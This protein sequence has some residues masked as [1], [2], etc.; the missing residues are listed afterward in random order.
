[1][2]NNLDQ[3]TIGINLDLSNPNNMYWNNAILKIIFP[4]IEDHDSESEVFSKLSGIIKS[5]YYG[6]GGSF[7][8]GFLIYDK[9]GKQ[10][11]EV[12]AS[13]G[14][15]WEDFEYNLNNEVNL[16]KF[17]ETINNEYTIEVRAISSLGSQASIAF[18]TQPE[19][20]FKYEN[21]FNV[22]FDSKDFYAN[23]NGR[24]SDNPLSP[25]IID[26]ILA[27]ELGQ[28]NIDFTGTDIMQ[29][30]DWQYAF[31]VDKKI[32]SKKLIE[33]IASAS[34]YIPRFDN[35]GNFKFDVIPIGGGTADDTIKEVDVIDF[36]FSRSKIEDVYT[37]IVFKYN[38]DY[39]RGEFNDSVTA[40][41]SL[42]GYEDEETELYKHDYYG[43]TEPYIEDGEEIHPD[44]TLVIDDDR[45]K[46]IRS[47]SGLSSTAR[48]FAEWYLLWS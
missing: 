25:I 19:A 13:S 33:G 35:M 48:D 46:Y 22:D 17:D 44:S 12:S 21:Y 16:T 9:D 10:F 4:T 41:I 7:Q 39:A 31:T 32:N 18:Q 3:G 14:T 29:D 2:L 43:F 38:W 6:F 37:K 42:V 30:Y 1:M 28:P 36:S 23:V 24:K 45:G 11:D 8:V 20:S 40:D 15:D 5:N 34:P 47:E 26:D 27:T